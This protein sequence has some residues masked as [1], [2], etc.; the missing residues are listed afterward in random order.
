MSKSTF[1]RTASFFLVFVLITLTLSGCGSK[2]PAASSGEQNAP[3]PVAQEKVM[4]VSVSGTPKI[5]PAVGMDYSSCIAFVNLYDSLV[6]PANDGSMEPALAEKWEV[7]E[8][9]LNYTFYLQKGIKFHNGDEI[10]ADDVVFSINRLMT[11]GEGF[12][13][14]FSGVVK[15]ASAV[16]DYTVK[17][18]LEKTFGPFVSTL[19]RLYVLN[20]DEVMQNINKEGS[21]GEFGDYGREWMI[22]HD[23]GSG[24]YVAKELQQQGYLYATKYDEY[25]KGWDKDAPDAIR[26]I[27]NTE[28]ATIRTMLGNKELEI[29]DMWQSTE[30]LQ[31]MSKIPGVSIAVYSTGSIQ[32]MM[33]N[34]KKAPTDDVNFRK[35]LSY[36]F[37]YKMI[38]DK[39]FPESPVAK[40]LA[41]TTTPGHK[42]DIFTYS[43]DLEKAKEYLQKSKYA[44]SLEQYPVELL[45]NTDVADHE[46]VALAFQAAASQAGIK[47]NIS[48]APWISITDQVS[49]VDTTPNIVCINVPVHYNEVG[50]MLETRY[51][52]KAVGTWEQAEWVQDKVLDAEIED[53]IA[54]VDQEERYEKYKRLQ[55]KIV[56]EIVPTVWLVEL[57]ERSAY[58]SDYVYWPAAES[59]KEGKYINILMGYHFYFHDFKLY[60]E[61]M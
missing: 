41:C 56:N 17:F 22:T 3:T 46:K 14:L 12:A 25:Y 27:D 32:N 4:R 55:D 53:A 19:A 51:H 42:E 7:D 30:N 59:A 28:G 11:I 29:T 45:V 33:L 47:V 49:K 58:Q 10:K 21:Y 1:K 8:S 31:A 9:G 40:G 57:N 54:T 20:K 52:S 16:D 61:K 26:L 13:Y 43:F 50:S 2:E 48:K 34:T 18:T 15:D 39:I 37:D 6:F 5:D 38:A 36:L 44:G 24:P 35:A 23:A 60:P